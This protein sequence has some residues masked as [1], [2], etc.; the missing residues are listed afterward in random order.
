M[1]RE[2]ETRARGRETGWGGYRG[3]Q[4]V[5]KRKREPVM[6]LGGVVER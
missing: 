2:E 5:G 4:R 3:R 6:G 1:K